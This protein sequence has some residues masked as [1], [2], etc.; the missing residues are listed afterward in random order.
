MSKQ[1]T[2]KLSERDDPQLSEFEEPRL[3]EFDEFGSPPGQESNE[4]VIAPDER[5]FDNRDFP[6]YGTLSSERDDRDDDDHD[7]Q[8]TEKEAPS[9]NQLKESDGTLKT[10]LSG[11][12][13]GPHLEEARK[14]RG[15][16]IQEVADR[17]YLEARIIEALEQ[18][19]YQPIPAPIFVQGYLRSYAKLLDLPPDKLL[20]LYQQ[21]HKPS[22]PSLSVPETHDTHPQIG[23]SGDSWY[24]ILTAVIIIGLMVLVVIWRQSGDSEQPPP[25]TSPE[26]GGPP[27]TLENGD[28]RDLTPQGEI[29]LSIQPA[30][31]QGGMDFTPPSEGAGEE[32]V[33]EAGEGSASMQ[34]AGE[35][36]QGMGGETEAADSETSPTE[37]SEEPEV[38][39]NTL[40][41]R[42]EGDSWTEVSD[43][44]NTKL[45]GRTA[46]AG[47]T[48]SL[49]GEP[50][51]EIVFGRVGEVELE[52]M[53]ETVDLGRYRGVAR[54]SLGPEGIRE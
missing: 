17:L 20:A 30:E 13:P 50:P 6:D 26:A 42:F 11:K 21:K 23:S 9:N 44:N 54:F 18:D 19:D 25:E 5:E 41:M 53:G 40:V 35:T 12:T 16:S 4:P 39:I 27:L 36:P 29:P 47:E 1:A 10:K 52:Y 24:K 7:W 48:V 32:G 2:R 28:P 37:A 31:G 33:S 8:A 45:Y 43:A 49:S 38:D 51:F 22:Q 14:A 3:N 46:R 34:A 15:W